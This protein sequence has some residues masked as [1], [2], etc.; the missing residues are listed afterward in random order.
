ML[1][2]SD[3]PWQAIAY[4]RRAATLIRTREIVPGMVSAAKIL[5]RA[6]GMNSSLLV[7]EEG[8]LRVFY[9]SGKSEAS[10]GPADMR[11]QRLMGHLPAL[12]HPDPK[13]VLVVGFGSGVTAGSF[14]PYPGVR[15]IVVSELEPEVPEATSKYFHDENYGVAADRRTRFVYDDAR[16]FI[17]TSREKF[18]EIGRA[19]V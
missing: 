14:V 8:G 4:G 9:V 7:T 19:H 16:H 18:D 6:E 1:F 3:L 17:L 11:L 5:F 15:N 12:L 2:R 13:D 10:S